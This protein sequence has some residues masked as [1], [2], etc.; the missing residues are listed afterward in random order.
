MS[1]DNR[2]LPAR[3]RFRGIPTNEIPQQVPLHLVL[4]HNDHIAVWLTGAHVYSTC[5]TF[6]AEASVPSTA[7][8]LG[9]YGFGKPSA[10]HTPPMLL[11]F[12]D[13]EGTRA[14]NLPGRATGLSANG[15]S[16]SGLTGR[17]GLV[18]CPVPSSGP[19]AVHFAWPHFG[20]GETTYTLDGDLFSSAATRVVT[21]W[22]VPDP[23]AAAQVDM[24]NRT[25]PETEIPDDGWFAAA[26]ELQKP[27][28]VDPNA[29]RRVNFAH[30]TKSQQ[31]R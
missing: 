13:A 14:T 4:A 26:F 24:D 31:Q 2:P 20:I 11:G 5:M 27:P 25:I 28:P 15:S 3:P 12:Q 19:L 17:V 30:V 7:L 22:D 9:M 21:L 18:L 6:T 29:P 16:G 10:T 1:N 23:A 8:F